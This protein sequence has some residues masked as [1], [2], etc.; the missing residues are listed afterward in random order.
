MESFFLKTSCQVD[1]G[2]IFMAKFSNKAFTFSQNADPQCGLLDIKNSHLTSYFNRICNF[3][4]VPAISTPIGRDSNEMPIGIQF[5]AK[6]VRVNECVIFLQ[7][8]SGTRKNFSKL[9]CTGR[10]RR[11]A[12][13][14]SFTWRIN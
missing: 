12:K 10:V 14:Q 5:I 7:F 8:S 1:Y 11:N 3:T 6:W 13:N 9:A 4:G 2:D